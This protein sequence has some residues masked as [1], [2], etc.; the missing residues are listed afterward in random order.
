MRL[1]L[2]RYNIEVEIPK[3]P[4]ATKGKIQ[5]H[6]KRWIVERTIAWALNNT[7]GSTDYERKIENSMAI[8][9]MTNIRRLIRKI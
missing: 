3:V 9:I 4:I 2:G 7:R 8:T 1:P 5:I 6:E